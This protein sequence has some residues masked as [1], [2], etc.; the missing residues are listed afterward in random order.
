MCSMPRVK[1]ATSNSTGF[2]RFV[3]LPPALYAISASARGFDKSTRTDVPLRVGTPLR[4]DFH[5]PVAGIQQSIEVTAVVRQLPMDSSELGAVLDQQRIQTLPLNRRDFLQLALLAPGVFPP[6]EDSELSSRGSFAMHVNGGRE[7]YNN[8]LLDGVDNN[9]PYVSGFVLQPAMDT[10]QEFKIGTN[11]YSAEY[12]RSGAGQVN[13]VT[14]RGTNQF[15]GFLY[16]YFRNGAL[17]AR[18]FF[19]GTDKPTYNRNQFGLGG[20]GPIVRD[21]SYFFANGDFLRERRGL[22]RLATV[23][24]EL[25][26][27]GNLS[28]L[29]KTI[30]DPFTRQPF[31]GNI[32]PPERISPIAREDTRA[33]PPCQPLRPRR[34]PSALGCNDKQ[35]EP[36]ERSIGSQADCGRR[37]YCAIQLWPCESL[38]A[39]CGG[40]RLGARLW[41]FPG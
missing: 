22:S 14:R 8:F 28:E 31:S 11:A 29:G 36:G 6:V 1:T 17:D 16:E 4:I 30:V 3:E 13:V 7:E 10:I 20:G 21:T 5:L 15:H 25:M 35:P 23:P 9:D 34:Q 32:I 19:D 41:G 12:G 27:S 2:Y 24:T 18:N 38:R 37:D 33:V 26:R 40:H 39:L